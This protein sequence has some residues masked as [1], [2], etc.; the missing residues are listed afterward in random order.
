MIISRTPFRISFFG[1]GTDYPSWYEENGGAVLS[2]SIDKYCYISCR[3]FPPFFD[4]KSRIVW[5]KI[6]SVHDTDE[7]EHPAIRGIL[8]HLDVQEGVEILHNADLPARAGLGSSSSFVVGLLSALNA[9]RGNMLTKRQ[10]AIAAIEMEQKILKEN[11]GSQDQTAAAFG[12]FNKIQFGGPQTVQVLPVTVK[13]AT[14]SELQ[15]HCMLFFTGFARTASEVAAEQIQNIKN[16]KSELTAMH[17]M[18]DEAIGILNKGDRIGDF[19]NLLHE[20]WKLKRGLSSRITDQNIDSI[21]DAA[22]KAG[23]SGG[24]ILGAGGGGFM[25]IFAEP[26]AQPK[27]K[28]AL[29]KLLH[30]PFRFEH[31]GS[32]IIYYAPAERYAS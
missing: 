31:A 10:L 16:K 4:H 5:S 15:D 12:G 32:Q 3:Y 7:I 1:G 11:V 27:V 8:K 22:R 13:A 23:A 25:L 20:S 6:E 9:L 18:V 19:G 30:V 14:L 26:E 21:Y 17:G 24:K 29:G 28:L 2:T